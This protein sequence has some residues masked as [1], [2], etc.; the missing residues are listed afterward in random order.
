MM[1]DNAATP[2]CEYPKRN[3]NCFP[4]TWKTNPEYWQDAG[5]TWQV[6]QDT[7]NFDDNPLAWFNQFQQA[8]NS[9]AL[10]QK[11]MAFLGLDDFYSQADQGKL[12]QVSIIIGRYAGAA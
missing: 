3:L 7:D 2:G 8:P 10:A 9:S 5:V 4:L 12:P 6:Y 1:L 11:G